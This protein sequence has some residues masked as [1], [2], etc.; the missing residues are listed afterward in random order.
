ML[1]HDL[2]LMLSYKEYLQSCVSEVETEVEDKKETLTKIVDE[3]RKEEES[4]KTILE[5]NQQ[6]ISTLRSIV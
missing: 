1:A 5:K 6:T 4:M 3:I 2:P